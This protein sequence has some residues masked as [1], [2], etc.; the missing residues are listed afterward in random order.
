MKRTSMR[1]IKQYVALT[2]GVIGTL[3]IVASVSLAGAAKPGS[4]ARM[5]YGSAMAQSFRLPGERTVPRG[6]AIKLGGDMIAVFDRNLMRYAMVAEEASIDLSN[7]EYMP[8]KGQTVPALKG[9]AI[10]ATDPAPGWAKS[11]RFS[12]PRDDKL[13]PLPEGWAQFEGYYR[14]GKKVILAYRVGDSRVLDMPTAIERAGRVAIARH[15]RIT[16]GSEPL[17]MRIA[18][19]TK[20]TKLKRT[21][22]G[23]VI[24]RE[25][26]SGLH[27]SLAGAPDKA[28]FEKSN[29]GRIE[30]SLPA[31]SKRYRF[32][33][34][35]A[36]L[37][38]GEKPAPA[39]RAANATE[40]V[41]LHKLARGGATQWPKVLT[42]EGKRAKNDSAYV[43]DTIPVPQDN[44]WGAFI[45]IS[46][47]AFYSDGRAAVCTMNGDVYLVTG[48]DDDLDGVRWKRFATGLYEPLG[49]AIRNGQM[50]VLEQGQ[51]TRLL[52]RNGDREADY[53][54]T[55]N[56][57]GILKPRAYWTDLAIDQADNV[58][59][60]RSGNRAPDTKGYGSLVRVSADGEQS[61]I[62]A[63]GLRQPNGLAM[64]P[65]KDVLM[66]TDQEGHWTP[67][68]RIDQVEQGDYIGYYPTS[69]PNTPKDQYA[70]PIC[71]VPKGVDNSA[72]SPVFIGDDRWGPLSG[73]WIYSSWGLARLNLLLTETVNGVRQG[74]VIPMPTGFFKS[75]VMRCRVG[76]HDGQLYTAG[77][78][79]SGWAGGGSKP[80]T[81][82]RVRYTG[83][84]CFMPVAM[85]ARQGGFE[86]TFASPI[87]SQSAKKLKNYTVKRWR[88]KRSSSYGSAAYSLKNP[89]Q[90]GRD[91]VK[92]SDVTVTANGKTVRL[93]IPDMQ[94][95]QQMMIRYNLKSATGQSVS[96]RLYP[97][98]HNLGK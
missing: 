75:G 64:H 87:E 77:L 23:L 82:R 92:V 98:L 50:F 88:Y 18:D 25:D 81:F 17:G 93:H 78:A 24:R 44:P 70:T 16:P 43:V 55:Y 89:G 94:P 90:K 58:Y 95:A 45:R 51:I 7:T 83:K 6:L 37:E 79:V 47:I 5:D 53:Y 13:G 80:A 63:T 4:M 84:P 31:K 39:L 38:K 62:Y 66:V 74:G 61:S 21:E 48:L 30:L 26:G 96:G 12:D 54:Q 52:D 72:A 9:E 56:A 15:L 97:T 86:L 46:G 69:P 27:L 11:G 49:I 28:R 19:V 1:R 3:A 36:P 33:L 59:Y 85:H 60:T 34:V 76:P 41:V 91:N 35:Q 71:W 32:R 22:T 68:T 29:G 10:F 65:S 67:A 40:P 73:H 20:I 8:S 14:H 2:P 57:D 42:R